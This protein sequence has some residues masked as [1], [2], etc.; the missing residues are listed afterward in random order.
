MFVQV[1]PK[2][3]CG[4]IAIVALEQHGLDEL[5][6]TKEDLDRGLARIKHRGPDSQGQWISHDD[7]VGP[8]H[9]GIPHSE[10]SS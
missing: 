1:L 8:L 4:S 7:R 10:N 5:S 2:N 6:R 9:R 3:M